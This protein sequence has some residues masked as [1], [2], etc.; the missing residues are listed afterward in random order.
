MNIHIV[1]L[2]LVELNRKW[3]AICT[4]CLDNDLDECTQGIA[5]MQND[6]KKLAEYVGES[7]RLDSNY[8]NT[9]GYFPYGIYRSIEE[10]QSVAE[11]VD[12][13]F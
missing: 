5:M 12:G 1:D 10:M 2:A 7:P 6:L 8:S 11:L 4:Y 3:C 9:W 13:G